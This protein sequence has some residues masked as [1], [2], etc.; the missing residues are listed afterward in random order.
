MMPVENKRKRRYRERIILDILDFL[1][2]EDHCKT[3]IVYNVNLNFR[4]TNRYL[5]R[6]VEIGSVAWNERNRKWYL[7][8]AGQD[9]RKA[10]KRSLKTIEAIL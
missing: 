3:D 9:C 7:T 2:V 5:E 6:L 8:P 10:L 4:V 1:A